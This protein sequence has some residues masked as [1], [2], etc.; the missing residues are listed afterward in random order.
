LSF[1][2]AF[3]KEAAQIAGIVSHRNTVN[4]IIVPPG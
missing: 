1:G 3:A 4:D 2:I